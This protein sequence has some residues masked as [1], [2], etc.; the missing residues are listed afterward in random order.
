MIKSWLKMDR[1]GAGADE[2]GGMASPPGDQS[3]GDQPGS[4]SETGNAE[5]GGEGAAAPV[6]ALDCLVIRKV[7]Q[8][9]ELHPRF[10]AQI[11][12][13]VSPFDALSPSRI[14]RWVAAGVAGGDRR[15]LPQFLA[16]ARL[17]AGY[18]RELKGMRK[19]LAQ[20]EQ[21]AA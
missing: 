10:R 6:N 2:P 15:L 18:Q 11:E 14:L 5:G 12:R 19:A 16:Q 8:S 9:P 20:G 1:D 3:S 7:A 13:T 4:G 17:M 21:A